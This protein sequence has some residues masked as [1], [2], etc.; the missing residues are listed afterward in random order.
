MEGSIGSKL[1]D[2]KHMSWWSRLVHWGVIQKTIDG[3]KEHYN[4]ER[5]ELLSARRRALDTSNFL[6]KALFEEQTKTT[7]VQER[8]IL[9]E[10]IISDL[11]SKDNE[12]TERYAVNLEEISKVREILETERKVLRDKLEEDRHLQLTEMKDTWRRH[13]NNV[14]TEIRLICKRYSIEYLGQ[15]DV[16]F[17]GKPDN[18]LVIGELFM[19]FDAKSPATDDLEN[20][21]RYIKT[22]ADLVKKYIKEKKVGNDIFLVV[23][24]N[25]LQVL[26]EFVY[27]IGTYKVH[28]IPTQALE[29]IITGLKKTEAYEF[30]EDLDPEVKES[31]IRIV[32]KIVHDVKRSIQISNNISSYLI[33]SLNN[34]RILPTDLLGKIE[35]QE[36]AEKYNPPQEQR[37]KIINGEELEKDI[38]FVTRTI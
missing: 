14:E 36:K 31:L 15:T 26:K 16:P 12:R 21:P 8:I 37:R 22:Q 17:K 28:V 9:L 5:N 23:P 19:V 32:G 13:E 20:F 25:T 7:S 30:G 3:I 38:E 27:E 18:T 6:E 11:Q 35:E 4:E 24:D 10:K 1:T 33:G 34:L 29:P 2:I